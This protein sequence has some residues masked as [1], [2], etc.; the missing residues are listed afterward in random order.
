MGKTDSNI[1]RLS[2]DEWLHFIL[3]TKEMDLS[4]F[5]TQVSPSTDWSGYSA[6]VQYASKF[7]STIHGVSFGIAFFVMA[8]EL[9]TLRNQSVATQ[10]LTAQ[11]VFKVLQS[12]LRKA[13]D[14]V[15]FAACL[16]AENFKDAYSQVFAVSYT[17]ADI[18][19]RVD[20]RTKSNN[21]AAFAAMS[22]V[23]TTLG[24]RRSNPSPNQQC[25]TKQVKAHARDSITLIKAWKKKRPDHIPWANIPCFDWLMD[26]GSCR[27]KDGQKCSTSS[28]KHTNPND[29]DDTTLII[30]WIGLHPDPH[31]GWV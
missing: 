28:F 1:I 6:I 16:T 4:L 27:G 11:D 2:K 20:M 3:L 30:E 13:P 8:N 5:I 7:L 24:K 31:D 26:C 17:D 12:R 22:P 19:E 9:L 18:R 15:R 23:A 29:D 21:D 14:D 25:A 10:I